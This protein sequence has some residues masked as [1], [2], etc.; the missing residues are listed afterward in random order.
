M[1]QSSNKIYPFAAIVGQEDLKL[2][3]ILCA[4]DPTIGG[5][6][7]RGD[8]GTAKSTAAR[9]LA[10]LLPR[11]KV[12]YNP[13]SEAFDPYNRDGD[14][15]AI[16]KNGKFSEIREIPTPFVDLPIGA[17]ED[18]VLGSLD[19]SATL[20]KS[21]KRVFAPGLL[22]AANRGIL[23]IDE[24]NL[25]PAHLV[26]VL[27]DTAAMGVNTVQ[28]EGITKTHPS[29]FMLIGTMNPEEGDIRPQ[30]LDRFGLM[31]D[32]LAPRDV[33]Q[34]TEVVRQRIAFERDPKNFRVQWE[35]SEARLAQKIQTAKDHLPQVSLSDD[36]LFL[37]SKICTEFRVDSLRADITMYKTATALAAWHGRMEVEAEDIRQAAEWVLAHRRR[38]QPFESQ[39]Q[40]KQHPSCHRKCVTALSLL[41]VAVS[42]RTIC[43]VGR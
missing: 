20:Q 40:C 11:I 17:T 35:E 1:P 16:D 38:Q 2:C 19:F 37:I 43:S 28:R 39:Q 26:D 4:I 8:K 31:V 9:G 22:A 29:K 27:L 41:A 34:R 23:Y 5:V 25:L 30:L 42:L 7:I 24:V 12:G 36:L 21:G 10:R 32:V 6:L 15:V 3:L 14:D 13:E 33:G 18:R